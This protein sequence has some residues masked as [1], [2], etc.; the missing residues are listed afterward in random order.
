MKTVE[1]DLIALA[2]AGHFDVIIHGANCF[3]AMGGGIAAQIAKRWP[4]ALEADKRTACGGIQKI[5]GYSCALVTT[6]ADSLLSVVNAY[7]QY[8]PG[9]EARLSAIFA[10]LFAVSASILPKARIGY[11]M[12]GCGIGGL[13]W[14]DVAPIF[15]DAFAG[16]DH[17]L[18]VL[19]RVAL[20]AAKRLR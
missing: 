10:A 2:D 5:G 3:H 4:E 20:G 17:T 8:N 13:A 9:R 12:I 16:R 15:D 6:A 18:V 7:T 1:G 19:P 11:P 14:K